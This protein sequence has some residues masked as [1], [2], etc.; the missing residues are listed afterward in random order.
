MSSG[1]GTQS[2]RIFDN[3]EQVFDERISSVGCNGAKHLKH[4]VFV[5]D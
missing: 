3:P 1:K 2:S 5:D 4:L